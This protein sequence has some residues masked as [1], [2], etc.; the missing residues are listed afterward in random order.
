[1][2][3]TEE[4]ELVAEKIT[5]YQERQAELQ[6]Q[7]L[8]AQGEEAEAE[9]EAEDVRKQPLVEAAETED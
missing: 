9:A 4:A 3:R 5:A 8:E 1:M 2:E 7:L 6:K